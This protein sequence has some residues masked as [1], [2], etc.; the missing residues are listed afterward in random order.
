MSYQNL[1]LSTMVYDR[2][3]YCLHVFFSMYID[4]LSVCLIKNALTGC[5][6]NSVWVNLL[7][8]ADDAVLLAPSPQAMQTKLKIFAAVHELTYNVKKMFG[9]CVRPK[10]LKNI[11]V[12]TL[13]TCTCV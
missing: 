12:P 11:I 13:C 10:W 5:V 8:Y 9:I 7:F 3:R 1:S 6:F 4:E 2:V